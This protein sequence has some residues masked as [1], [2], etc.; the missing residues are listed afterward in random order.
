MPSEQGFLNLKE[1]RK[2][3]GD[4]VELQILIQQV[5]GGGGDAAFL[6]STLVMLLQLV[7]GT[8]LSSKDLRDDP[9]RTVAVGRRWLFTFVALSLVFIS[10]SHQPVRT[11]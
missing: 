8:H 4:S 5:W 11:L 7:Q 10:E 6:T 2:S 1:H 3:P 9:S